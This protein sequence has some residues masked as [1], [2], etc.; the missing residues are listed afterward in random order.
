[1]VVRR[2]YL[3]DKR[4]LLI[5]CIK[6][7]MLDLD[8]IIALENTNNILDSHD[9]FMIQCKRVKTSA[10]ALLDYNFFDDEVKAVEPFQTEIVIKNPET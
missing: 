4:Q 9:D 10:Q 1:V 6:R 3:M 5:A 8:F 7:I 2:R